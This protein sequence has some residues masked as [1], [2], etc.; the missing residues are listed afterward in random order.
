MNIFDPQPA[1]GTNHELTAPPPQGNAIGAS[2]DGS[3]SSV[4]TTQDCVS[5]TVV[6]SR[7]FLTKTV[8]VDGDGKPG[9]SGSI[10][11][12]KGTARRVTLT[13]TATEI[14]N[15]LA[16]QLSDLGHNE[17]LICAPAPAGRDEWP[18]VTLGNS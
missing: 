15:Q 18:L 13:G 9:A 3:W 8:V 11:L 12:T 7:D 17:A 2:L 1:P 16:V 4:G 5:F 14:I 6:E 10:S